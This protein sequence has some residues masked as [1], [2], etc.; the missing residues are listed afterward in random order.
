MYVLQ[1]QT[2]V[3]TQLSLL[4]YRALCFFRIFCGMSALLAV[5]EI[6]VK[7][8]LRY[9]YAPLRV[10]KASGESQSQEE[11]VWHPLSPCQSRAHLL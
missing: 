9:Y 1:V 4:K 5:R 8:T 6:H 7:P 2:A 10:V 11:E 3:Y